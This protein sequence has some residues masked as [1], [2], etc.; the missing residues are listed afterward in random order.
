MN[1]VHGDIKQLWTVEGDSLLMEFLLA[2]WAG[3]SRNKVKS[4]LA[5]RHVYV[6]DA[7]ET[8]FDRALHAGDTV[9]VMKQRGPSPLRH[10]MLRI[11]YEDRYIVVIDKRSGLLSA[12]TDKEH[13]RTANYIL[14]KHL[15]E[16]DPSGEIF[17][18]HR[19]DRD[20]SGIMMYAKSREIKSRL[21]QTWQEA[22]T[23]RQYVAVAEGDIPD[24]EGTIDVPLSENAALKVYP[25]PAGHR[26]VTHYKVLERSGKY[27]LVELTLE[28]GRKNQ[29]RAHLEY[30]GHP[31]AGDPKYGAKSDPI[32]RLCLHAMR[33]RIIH[34]VTGA[35]MDFATPVPR[36]FQKIMTRI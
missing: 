30:I 34:P 25:D 28:T 17:V 2:S 11:I 27:T 3:M 33:L 21:Q 13:F 32:G 26:A 23:L 18:V 7:L 12:D 20:T 6:N 4:H 36:E 22:V 1:S 29:I 31:V 24:D 14:T 15:R 9:A 16:S 5:N 10:P 19:L 35:E 8:R